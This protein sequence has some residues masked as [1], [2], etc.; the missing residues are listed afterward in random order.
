MTTDEEDELEVHRG[1]LTVVE[2]MERRRRRNARDQFW[3]NAIYFGGLLLFVSG[4]LYWLG[5]IVW[6]LFKH[7]MKG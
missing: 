5:A 4:E 6:G 1:K 3:E 7:F 2:W